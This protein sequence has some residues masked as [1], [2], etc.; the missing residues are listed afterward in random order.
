M[1]QSQAIMMFRKKFAQYKKIMEEQGETKAWEKL[2]KGYP[3]RQKDNLGKFIDNST[4]AAGFKKGIELY[5]QFGMEMEVVDISNR[6]IDAV[7]EIQRICPVLTIAKEYGFS[8]P[9]HIICEM[10]VEATKK[11]FPGI[12]GEILAKQADG[13]CVCIFKYERRV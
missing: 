10:D 12:S 8:K 7:L 1:E 13:A 5:K 6:G 11:A 2:F 9:C 3:E 4:L